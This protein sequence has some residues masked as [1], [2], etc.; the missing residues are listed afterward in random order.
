[1]RD[2]GAPLADRGHVGQ[3]LRIDERDLRFRVVQPEFERVGAEQERQRH[4]DRAEAIDRD[5]RD[6]GLGA[7]RKDQR[8]L[9]AARDT[10]RRQRIREAVRLLLQV[11]ERE[12]GGRAGF[13]FPVEREARAVGR[14]AAAAR[15]GDRE[16]RRHVPPVR[17]M[18]FGVPV[19]RHW[20]ISDEFAAFAPDVVR[21]TRV[22]RRRVA[23]RP[24]SPASG[25]PGGTHGHGIN[26]GARRPWPSPGD[27]KAR[28]RSRPTPVAARAGGPAGW[29]CWSSASAA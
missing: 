25:R 5:V 29:R 22:G 24:R 27:R 19:R 16:A 2:A 14:P 10:H 1:M 13:V 26:G 18:D 23:T 8:D 9:V 7:L 15:F 12:R 6:D 28:R 3:R 20:P 4:G 11:P 17:R 21:A